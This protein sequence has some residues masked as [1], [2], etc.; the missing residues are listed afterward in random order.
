MNPLWFLF[1]V[2]AVA[3]FF[4]LRTTTRRRWAAVDTPTIA[5]GHVVIGRVEV[6]GPAKPAGTLP[7]LTSPLSG[8]QCVWW[9]AEVQHESGSSK[10]KSWKTEHTTVSADWISVDDGSGPVLVN[11]PNNQPSS[12]EDQAVSQGD[13]PTWLTPAH[14]AQVVSGQV[15]ATPTNP[16]SEPRGV[17]HT[18]VNAF[19]KSFHPDTPIA[20]FGG[21]WRVKESVIKLDAPMYVLGN[22]TYEESTHRTFFQAAKGKPLFVYN[23]TEKE[24][25]GNSGWLALG[26]CVALMGS[27]CMTAMLWASRE[28][29]GVRELNVT[30]GVVAVLVIMIL[31]LVV[32][33]IRVRNRVAATYQQVR[34]GQGLVD[35][36]YQKR[37]DLIPQL[38]SVVQAAAGHS[39]TVLPMLAD[40]RA[41]RASG[42][43]AL[44]ELRV[45][46]ERLP[47]LR[48]AENFVHLQKALSGVE[49]DLAVA[50]GFVAD[51]QA[52]HQTRIQSFPDSLIARVFAVG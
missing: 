5:T 18:L 16:P 48:T 50:K 24:L 44:D 7:V 27:G 36:A 51:A 17:L 26:C 22:T 46:V 45:T 8:E 34:A 35:I 33:V 9:K 49:T 3:S 6:R 1:P 19:G 28:V 41:S 29:S 25:V 12:T 11:I 20:E 23:G 31:A 10:S 39:A 21:K 43:A 2:L 52:V 47:T 13:L 14:L 42:T 32:Q 30:A 4:G 15:L 40:L 38:V 37:A